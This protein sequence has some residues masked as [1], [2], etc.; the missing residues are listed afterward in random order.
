MIKIDDAPQDVFW[1]LAIQIADRPIGLDTL[2][3]IKVIIKANPKYFPWETKYDSIPQEVHDA[4][5][6]EKHDES[7]KQWAEYVNGKEQDGG[8]IGLIPTLMQM[9]AQPSYPPSPEKSLSDIFNDLF[10][11]QEDERK[12]KSE[13]DKKNKALWDRHYKPYGLEYRK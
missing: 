4:Y 3:K 11:Q 13:E 8:F 9:D 1:V 5:W 10:K 2:N 12:R 7:D 6:K